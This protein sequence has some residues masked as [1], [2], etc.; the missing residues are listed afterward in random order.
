MKRV[1]IKVDLFGR[2]WEV[3][4]GSE[5]FR[6]T[7][8]GS[9]KSAGEAALKTLGYVPIGSEVQ[10]SISTPFKDWLAKRPN[11]EEG[12]QW[13]DNISHLCKVRQLTLKVS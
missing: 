1:K 5:I 12:R 2:N 7:F 10:L 6:G 11:S 13:L 8:A 3:D 4:T 9:R